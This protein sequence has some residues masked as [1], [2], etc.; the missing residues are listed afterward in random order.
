MKILFADKKLTQFMQAFDLFDES[1]VIVKGVIYV[2]FPKINKEI[3]DKLIANGN[4]EEYELIA[5]YDEKKSYYKNPKIK[6]ISSG[7]NFYILDEYIKLGYTFL[8]GLVLR[9][10]NEKDFRG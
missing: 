2:E 9:A 3:I 1:K 6:V 5:I 8:D 4:N 10:S 7:Y